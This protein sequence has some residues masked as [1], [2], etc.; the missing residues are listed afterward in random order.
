MSAEAIALAIA[1][2]VVLF[3]VVMPFLVRPRKR[4]SCG[5]SQWGT[6]MPK[7]GREKV[8]FWRT[9]RR[10]SAGKLLEREVPGSFRRPGSL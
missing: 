8:E 2:R 9:C 7:A 6:L 5:L 4:A 10:Y 1:E 3:V